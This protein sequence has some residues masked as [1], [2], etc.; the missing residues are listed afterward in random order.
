MQF[1]RIPEAKLSLLWVGLAVAT[2]QLLMEINLEEL[3]KVHPSGN[4]RLAPP[5]ISMCWTGYR[6]IVAG[7]PLGGLVP[8]TCCPNQSGNLYLADNMP[9]QRDR[10]SQ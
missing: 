7:T 1:Q 2:V 5:V 4:Q 9:T 8:A 10:V 3:N 6:G